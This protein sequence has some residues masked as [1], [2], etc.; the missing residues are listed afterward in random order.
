MYACVVLEKTK[1]PC[2]VVQQ[3]LEGVRVRVRVGMGVSASLFTHAYFHAPRV[4][5]VR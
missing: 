3:D 2:L 4:L 5:D 1:C